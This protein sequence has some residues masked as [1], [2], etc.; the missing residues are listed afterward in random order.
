MEEFRAVRDAE[1]LGLVAGD[2]GMGHLVLNVGNLHV[3]SPADVDVIFVTPK[4]LTGGPLVGGRGP[5]VGG[6]FLG[7]EDDQRSFKAAAMLPL[8]HLFHSPGT[9]KGTAKPRIRVAVG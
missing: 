2:D 3:R 7:L 1:R 8:V 9:K 6:L 5:P 4:P